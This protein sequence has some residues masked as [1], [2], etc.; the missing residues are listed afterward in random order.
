MEHIEVKKFTSDYRKELIPILKKLGFNAS[1]T[2]TKN[3]YWNSSEISVLI[4]TVPVN[5]KVWK[6][7]YKSDY[8][9][10]EGAEKLKKAIES[11]LETLIK[12]IDDP[13][14]PIEFD[15]RFDSKIQYNEN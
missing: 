14:A 1:I 15:I 9:L 7:A 5:F 3:G 13:A 4:N 10:L 2:T 11:R 12:D 6:D 8:R